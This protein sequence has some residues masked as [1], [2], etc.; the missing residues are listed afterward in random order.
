MTRTSGISMLSAAATSASQARNLVNDSATQL[1]IEES[2]RA[3]LQTTLDSRPINTKRKYEGYQKEFVLWCHDKHFCDGSTVTKGK[4]HL[5]LSK[6]VV[7]RESK[8]KKGTTVR[9]STVCGYANAVVDL[10]SQQ[11]AL[12]VNSNEHPRSAQ[13]KQL[14]RNVQAKSTEIKKKNYQDRGVGSLLDGYHSELQFR[15]ICDSFFCLM[16]YADALRF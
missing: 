2:E 13:V 9:G 6:Q 15:Q 11:V 16:I 14:L 10:Y 1:Q 5:F 4:L 7:G 8:K 12:R 3:T